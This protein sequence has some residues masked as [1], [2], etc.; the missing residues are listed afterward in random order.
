MRAVSCLA[1]VLG[2]CGEPEPWWE[3]HASLD[4][5]LRTSVWQVLEKPDRLELLTLSHHLEDGGFHGYPVLGRVA[6]EGE[7]AR[8]LV[9]GFY[10]SARDGGPYLLCFM[11]HHALHAE[12]DGR[13]VDLVLC[14][15]CLQ[16]RLYDGGER[17]YTAMSA[18]AWPLYERLATRYLL[19]VEIEP[20]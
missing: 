9:S 15:H 16:Y 20:M 7:E 18:L 10:Q 11:P 13:V 6:L 8:A 1:L 5:A 19:P 2:A 3:A 17:P 12:R 4:R 14:F